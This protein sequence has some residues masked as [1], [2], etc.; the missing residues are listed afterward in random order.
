MPFAVINSNGD[1]Q[2]FLHN[3]CCNNLLMNNQIIKH[4]IDNYNDYKL[5]FIM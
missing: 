1:G 2:V 5:V 3:N 4:M